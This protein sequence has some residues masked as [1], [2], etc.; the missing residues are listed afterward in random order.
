MNGGANPACNL[1]RF[2]VGTAT[3]GN[4]FHAPPIVQFVPVVMSKVTGDVQMHPASA[5]PMVLAD[6]Y[7]AKHEARTA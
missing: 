2:Y 3:Q 6:H 4:C 5:R 7:C 1:C